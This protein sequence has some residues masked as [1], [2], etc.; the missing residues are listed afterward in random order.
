MNSSVSQREAI[1]RLET[2]PAMPR[3]AQEI[4]ALP[5]DTDAGEHELLALIGTDPQI[6]ARVIGLANAPLF[7]A[8]RRVTAI[9]D[10]TILL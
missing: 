5:L 7:G 2:L 4:M 9:N 10:A 1:A 6:S 3:I 8:S